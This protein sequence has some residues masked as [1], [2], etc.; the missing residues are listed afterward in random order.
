MLIDTAG[1]VMNMTGPVAWMVNG[2]ALHGLGDSMSY[3]GANV[4]QDLAFEFSYYDF[5]VCYGK[6]TANT[7]YHRKQSIVANL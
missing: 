5:D 6:A 4:W 3:N 1:C 2:I 7:P